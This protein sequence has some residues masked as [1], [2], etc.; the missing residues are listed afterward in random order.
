MPKT[1]DSDVKF[2]SWGDL[3]LALETDYTVSFKQVCRI[4]KTSRSWVT[5]YIRPF[6]RTAYISSGIRAD[7]SKGVNWLLIASKH[8]DRQI[9]ESVWFHKED[10]EN[11]I[12]NSIVSVT[13]Q[14]KRIP[15]TFF[16]PDSECESYVSN[17]QRIKEEIKSTK[18]TKEI[19]QLYKELEKTEKAQIEG[20]LI[21]DLDKYHLFKSRRA[22]QTDRT[23]TPAVN[24]PL[25]DNYVDNWKAVHDLK[26]Y[27]DADETIYRSLFSSGSIRI[28]L[29]FKDEKGNLGK[30]IFYVDDPDPIES[31]Y[32]DDEYILVSEAAWLHYIG[33]AGF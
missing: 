30:K 28:E 32:G 14:T 23:K 10:L 16:V 20:F 18:D 1:K 5:K 25:P 15:L 19:E 17:R 26:D 21:H 4:L 12:G 13:K 2:K 11:F 22:K 29:Q 33:E 7:G 8:L 9:T 31:R 24:V 3:I 27:G 6:V